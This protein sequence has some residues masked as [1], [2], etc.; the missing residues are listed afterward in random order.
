M[1]YRPSIGPVLVWVSS[2][3]EPETRTWVQGLYLSVDPRKQRS[4]TGKEEMLTK[5]V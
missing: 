1:S 5:D 2:K 4:E 3:A